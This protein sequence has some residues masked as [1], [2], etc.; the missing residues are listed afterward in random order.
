MTIIMSLIG[1]I[2]FVFSLFTRSFKEALKRLWMFALTGVI[3][4]MLLIS[5]SACVTYVALH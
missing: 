2:V 5:I 4:D 1:V 3:I